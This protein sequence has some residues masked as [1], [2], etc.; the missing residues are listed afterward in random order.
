MCRT[1]RWVVLW[2]MGCWLGLTAHAQNSVQTPSVLVNQPA[3]SAP[4][5]ANAMVEAAR[6]LKIDRCLPALQRLSS[7]ELQRAAMHDVVLDWDR[8]MPD[9]S[10]FFA[11]MGI[12]TPQTQSTH[13]ATY[14]MVPNDKGGCSMLVERIV[15]APKTCRIL[16]NEEL[17][18]YAMTPFLPGMG[19]LTHSSEPGSTISLIDAGPGCLILRRFVQYHWRTPSAVQAPVTGPSPAMGLR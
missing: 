14:T 10:P 13:A 5:P 15:W 11:L 9:T 1:R 7:L 19:V 17:P 18:G 12:T 8:E 16:A 3:N 2:T 6:K 4:M